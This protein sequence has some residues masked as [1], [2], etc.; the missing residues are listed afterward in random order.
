MVGR[1][2]T[3]PPEARD[4]AHSLS[5][6]TSCC[7]APSQAADG[8]LDAVCEKTDSQQHPAARHTTALS[9]VIPAYNEAKR[10]PRFLAAVRPYM[11]RVFG[12][13]YEVIV[14][15]DGSSDATAEIVATL[16][17]SWPQ[18][19][20]I[21]HAVNRG[22]G[23][24]VRTG[25]QASVGDMVLFADAD[26]ACSVSEEVRLR[27]AILQGADI[28]VGS[29]R[30]GS[31]SQVSRRCHRRFMGWCFACATR[32]TTGLAVRDTQCGFKMFRRSVAEELFAG[33][34]RDDYLFDIFVLMCAKAGGH[35]VKEIG[36][37]WTE[38]PG[39]QLHILRD[40][41]EMV[42]GLITMRAHVRKHL[43]DMRE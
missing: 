39:S 20:V 9:L 31:P 28:A 11:Q 10:L 43:R 23:G 25:V 32:V 18:L 17:H 2:E 7:D 1:P 21:R 8:G 22:K 12:E 41:W 6:R 35:R 14:V 24:A 29:R 30:V 4:M 3:L 19:R 13:S 36:V 26:G 16:S 33:C 34:P 38:I 15:D 5:R 40:S 37:M 27:E 42:R